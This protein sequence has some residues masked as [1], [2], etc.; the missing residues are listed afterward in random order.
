MYLL[1]AKQ[2]SLFMLTSIYFCGFIIFS[3]MWTAC[4]LKLNDYLLISEIHV[5]IIKNSSVVQ[6][7]SIDMN[8]YQFSKIFFFSNL[9]F[10]HLDIYTFTFQQILPSCC[11]P[12]L[13]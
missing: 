7:C 6:A 10:Q 3:Q 5:C 2:A 12:L 4:S 13:L 11:G 9:Y 8:V 1:T